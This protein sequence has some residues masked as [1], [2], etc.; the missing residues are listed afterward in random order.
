MQMTTWP[1]LG[2]RNWGPGT[3]KSLSL[4][5][6]KTSEGRHSEETCA[7]N[8][9]EIWYER[10]H[11]W[12][13]AWMDRKIIEG[14]IDR[15]G[16]RKKKWWKGR[17]TVPF[18]ATGNLSALGSRSSRHSSVYWFWTA[19]A[20]LLSNKGVSI[21]GYGKLFI[22]SKSLLSLNNPLIHVLLNLSHKRHIVFFTSSASESLHQWSKLTCLVSTYY[23]AW[24]ITI[25][26][27]K[28]LRY[29]YDCYS[30]QNNHTGK[31]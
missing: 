8:S 14:L 28:W 23:L 20:S 18:L 22:L 11:G 12:M 24:S 15:Y 30:H 25:K 6:L 17:E 10:M 21:T 2:I 9:R 7:P 5:Y 3:L 19:L 27:Y 13:E 1:R 31:L 26:S 4:L 16:P 29:P